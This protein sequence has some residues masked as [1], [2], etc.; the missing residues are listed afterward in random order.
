MM[1]IFATVIVMMVKFATAVVTLTV[2]TTATVK[3]MNM[4]MV[5]DKIAKEGK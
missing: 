3:A 4:V 2:T 1:I 5:I